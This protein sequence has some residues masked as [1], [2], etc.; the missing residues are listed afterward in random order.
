MM[1]D[2]QWRDQ[3][4]H[5]WAKHKRAGT[6][7]MRQGIKERTKKKWMNVYL[8]TLHRIPDPETSIMQNDKAHGPTGAE[9][10]EVT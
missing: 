3:T 9:R 7:M 1:T 10:K 8:R 6:L 2:E 5:L 4:R